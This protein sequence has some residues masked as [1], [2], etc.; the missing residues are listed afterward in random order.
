MGRTT[1]RSME[2]MKFQVGDLVMIACNA[3]PALDDYTLMK[4]NNLIGHIGTV[5]E[6]K[7]FGYPY[8]VKFDNGVSGLFSEKE[9]KL[10]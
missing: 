2:Q 8:I 5:E 10:A 6:T 9:L 7:T 4:Y 1:Y 3:S